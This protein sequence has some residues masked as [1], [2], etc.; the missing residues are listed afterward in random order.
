MAVFSI[1]EMYQYSSALCAIIGSPGPRIMVGGL[2][3]AGV[4][5]EASVK[6]V[7]AGTCP[8]FLC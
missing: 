6:K 7:A 5:I 2:P 4:K 8:L 3:Q 1:F